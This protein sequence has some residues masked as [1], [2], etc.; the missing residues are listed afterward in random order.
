MEKSREEDTRVDVL[1]NLRVLSN[2]YFGALAEAAN[3][4]AFSRLKS[5]GTPLHPQV[6][7][8]PLHP[9]VTV[10]PNVRCYQQHIDALT[11]GA[12]RM[13][14]RWFLSRWAGG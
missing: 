12:D 14:A 5:E 9:Y 2:H 13:L 10:D 1:T 6:T 4:A 8:G 7:V 3:A 11:V